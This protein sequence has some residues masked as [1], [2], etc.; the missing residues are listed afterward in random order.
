[1][2]KKTI[3]I[4]GKKLLL[5]IK[6]PEELEA[7]RR[8]KEVIVSTIN[9]IAIPEIPSPPPRFDEKENEEDI[10]ELRSI[11]IKYPLIPKNPKQGE[12]VFAYAHIFFDT[13]SNELVY[14]VI[15][16]QLDESMKHLLEQIKEYIQEKINISLGEVRRREAFVYIS[17]IFEKALEYLKVKVDENTKQVL[18]YYLFRDFVGLE[19]IEP[20][21]NDGQIEDI[22]CDGVGINLYVYHRNPKLG[23]LKTNVVFNSNE[24]LD[25]FVNKL[26][27]RCGKGISV[28]RPLMDGTLPD[29]SRVQATLSTD[30]ARRGSNFTIRMFTETPL[31]P[32]DMIEFGTC[33]LKIL[34]YFWFLVEY[35]FS[36]LV[37]GGTAT[38]KT[39]LLNVLSLF[40]KPQMKIVSIEDTSELRLPHFHWVPEVAR[41]PISEEG[42]VDLFE[43]L[44]ESLRKRPDYIILGEVRGKEAYVLFQQMAIGHPGLSTMHSENIDKL[45]DRLTT[46]PINLPPNLIQNLD[47]VI[48]LKRIKKGRRYF[49]RVSSVFEILGFDEGKPIVN[50]VFSWDAKEDKYK[51]VNDSALLKKISEHTVLTD[52]GVQEEIIK[53]AAILRF[54]AKQNVKDY[55]KIGKVF[56]IF[57]S[58]PESLLERIV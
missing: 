23:S 1:M 14:N 37:C 38:G 13:R 54:L 53:R 56:N 33:D 31:T 18:S 5:K 8:P 49:R 15:E 48:F 43:L 39:S 34:S 55:R 11:D 2:I 26:S 36:F 6:T 45:I 22:S 58:S 27:E 24:D 19:K 42:K 29:G 20:F 40:I 32:V 9:G 7:E 25:Y 30:I 10:T 28:A 4:S 21:I 46:P 47:V 50:E 41:T 35:N 51:I 3:K 44:R 52:K 57:Y 17:E 16:P 12:R